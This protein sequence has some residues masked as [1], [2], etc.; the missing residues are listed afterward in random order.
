M[1]N[2]ERKIQELLNLAGKDTID[3]KMQYIIYRLASGSKLSEFDISILDEINEFFNNIGEE[4]TD[5]ERYLDFTKIN[6]LVNNQDLSE[7]LISEIEKE[8]EK[9][10]MLPNGDIFS[11]Y[12]DVAILEAMSSRESKALDYINDILT[13]FPKKDRAMSEPITE[14]ALTVVDAIHLNS[15]NFHR[16]DLIKNLLE[17]LPTKKEKDTFR[18]SV[19]RKMVMRDEF[20]STL[21]ENMILFAEKELFD[22]IDDKIEK[23]FTASQIAIAKIML[24]RIENNTKLI[25]EGR[26]IIT[27]IKNSIP[28]NASKMLKIFRDI[29][30]FKVYTRLEMESEAS[31]ILEDIKYRLSDFLSSE[32]MENEKGGVL[33]FLISSLFIK[34]F[35]GDKEFRKMKELSD[36]FLEKAPQD[37]KLWSYIDISTSLAKFGNA[38]EALMELKNAENYV[39]FFS[40][41]DRTAIIDEIFNSAISENYFYTSHEEFIDEL[42]SLLKNLSNE[43]KSEIASEFFY[44]LAQQAIN[45]KMNLSI[46]S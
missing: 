41:D 8:L 7:A 32:G 12:R 2:R 46:V 10:F 1:E 29:T 18:G 40:K 30:L 37:V 3:E 26:D 9:N 21:N 11:I 4:G 45:K 38:E 24:G 43:E 28:K 14:L 6:I 27:F 19:A 42:L 16:T 15:K 22:K 25:D 33:Y 44:N 17:Y 39:E 34:R 20:T 31:T 36:T 35:S 5:F 13:F 23:I